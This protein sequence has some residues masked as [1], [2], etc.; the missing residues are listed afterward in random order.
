MKYF[1]MG[2]LENYQAAIGCVHSL[3]I[4]LRIQTPIIMLTTVDR[5]RQK[6]C[7]GIQGATGRSM[8]RKLMLT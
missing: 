3:R 8:E 5:P 2:S 4:Q 1:D 6:K 7:K